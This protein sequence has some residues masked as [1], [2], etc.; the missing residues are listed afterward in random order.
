MTAGGPAQSTQVLALWSYTQSFGLHDFGNGMAIAMVLLA[1][2]LAIVIPYYAWMARSG[3]SC[4]GAHRHAATQS[5]SCSGS[6]C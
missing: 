3:A 4:E 1:V 5:R 6:S 2:T